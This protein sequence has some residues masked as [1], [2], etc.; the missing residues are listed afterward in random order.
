ME[1]NQWFK[2][3]DEIPGANNQYYT[4]DTSGYYTVQVRDINGCKSDISEPYYFDITDIVTV[5]PKRNNL[6]LIPNPFTG[7]TNIT[8]VIDKSSRVSLV[9][10]NLM[11]IEVAKIYEDVFIDSGEHSIEFNANELP[12]GVYFCTLRAGGYTESVKM[13]V[14]R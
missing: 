6:M 7:K 10:T 12:A 2:G 4:P 11:G 5:Y 3:G 1:G 13:V 14:V 9:I 8:W